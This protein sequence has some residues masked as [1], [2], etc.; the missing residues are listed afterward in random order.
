MGAGGGG[1]SDGGG[2]GTRAPPTP[3]L[4]TFLRTFG[5][6]ASREAR[7]GV[8]VD[9]ETHA[10]LALLNVGGASGSAG[11]SSGSAGGSSSASGSSSFTGGERGGSGHRPRRHL[12]D[13]SR[14]SR[15]K[16]KSSGLARLARLVCVAGEDPDMPPK[17]VKEALDLFLK[18]VVE[19]T[20]GD[21]FLPDHLGDVALEA[22][23]A[24]GDDVLRHDDAI[25]ARRDEAAYARDPNFVTRK[26]DV[27]QRE[28]QTKELETLRRALGVIDASKFG[29]FRERAVKLA[30]MA[31]RRGETLLN[32][33]A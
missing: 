2:S 31:R 29:A 13:I 3:R 4:S 28:C 11:R 15:S 12:S 30:A 22:F 17:N 26:T 5:T 7:S 10:R 14:E 32:G 18:S 8:D 24:I 1:G 16:S 20:G 21:T 33:D 9:R 25:A 6:S 19:I 23:T 27:F